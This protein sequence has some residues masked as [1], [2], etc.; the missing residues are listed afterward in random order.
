MSEDTTQPRDD[1][2]GDHTTSETTGPESTGAGAKAEAGDSHAARIAELSDA[3]ETV[4]QEVLYAKAETQN[5]RRR[6]EKE[7]ADARAYA[8]TGIARDIL[9]VADNIGRALESIPAELRDDERMKKE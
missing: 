3:L 6:F 7:V 2:A 9:S 8:A 1:V 5:V 4:R